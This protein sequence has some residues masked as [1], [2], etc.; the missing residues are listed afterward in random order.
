MVDLGCDGHAVAL[1][2]HLAL[3]LSG[4]ELVPVRVTRV[5]VGQLA[6][7]LGVGHFLDLARL[8]AVRQ[9]GLALVLVDQVASQCG[10]TTMASSRASLVTGPIPSPADRDWGLVEVVAYVFHVL[11]QYTSY[12][13]S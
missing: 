3:L 4:L 9:A 12:T 8:V 2:H 1:G 11:A 10:S 6:R 13:L 5:R 7:G